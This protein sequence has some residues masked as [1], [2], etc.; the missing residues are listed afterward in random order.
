MGYFFSSSSMYV[1]AYIVELGRDGD[2]KIF[3]QNFP[4][5]SLKK[6]QAYKKRKTIFTQFF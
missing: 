3:I 4:N 1:N 2:L 6:I 5:S